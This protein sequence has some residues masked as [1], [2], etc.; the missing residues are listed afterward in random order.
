MRNKKTS[1]NHQRMLVSLAYTLTLDGLG[2]FI[3]R[4][5]IVILQL[6]IL[7]KLSVDLVADQNLGHWKGVTEIDR[8]SLLVQGITFSE[9]N[10]KGWSL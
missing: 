7:L 3:A 10:T 9:K 1:D 2:N 5:T 4:T 8:T 6:M